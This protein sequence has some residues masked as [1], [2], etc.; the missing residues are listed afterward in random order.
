MARRSP[1]QADAVP[2][3]VSAYGWYALLVLV[4]VYVI[5]F[6]DRQIISIL[7]QDIKHD[8]HLAGRPD[9]LPLRHRLRRLLRL[10]RNPA[11]AARGQLVSRP[12]DRDRPRPVVDDDRACRASPARSRCSPS[13]RI[14]VGIGEASASPAAY[15]MIS[16]Y[17]PKE[18][19]A[20]ALSIYSAGLY[21]GGGAQPAGRRAR[22]QPLERGLA[23]R[24][25]RAARPGR[26][27]G[28]LPRGRHT[29]P[30]ARF[31]GADPARAAA[32]RVGRACRSRW[33]GPTPGAISAASWSRSC[34]R[35]PCSARRGSP[36]RAARQPRRACRRS[37]RSRPA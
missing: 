25:G 27:A 12:A 28:R 30:A 36:G 9:R 11:R 4:L 29:G 3:R 23:A 5:N 7:A 37:R 10:V 32:R 33:C 8:L 6:I 31:V 15:S 14:G 2:P 16:D 13:A 24:G 34:R 20:T 1:A 35:S 19:R 21:I 18:K 26:L 17:F 22:Q